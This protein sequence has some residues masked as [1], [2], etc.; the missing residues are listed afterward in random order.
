[1]KLPDNA[2]P[3]L[4]RVAVTAGKTPFVRSDLNDYSHPHTHVRPSARGKG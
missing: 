3:L 4:E 1:M 2:C